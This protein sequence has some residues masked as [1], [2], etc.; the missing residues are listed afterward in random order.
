MSRSGTVVSSEKR[1]DVFCLRKK[2]AER[3]PLDNE[4]DDDIKTILE[5]DGQIALTAPKAR[6]EDCCRK[7][8]KNRYRTPRSGSNNHWVIVRYI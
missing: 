5:Y 7:E 1:F 6:G 2:G 8:P 4:R 3:G